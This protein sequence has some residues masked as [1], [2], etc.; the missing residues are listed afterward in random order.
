MSGYEYTVSRVVDA[1]VAKVW[2]VWTQPEHY[3][4]VFHAVPG[5]AVLDVR[6]G[7]SWAVTMN[8]PDAGEF[9]MSGS[10]RDVVPNQRL[11]TTMDVPG[12][13]PEAMAMDLKDLGG[14]RTELILSQTCDTAEK[15]DESKQG[16][17]VLLEWCADYLATL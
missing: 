16:S 9:P 5:S 17:E 6:P 15:R 1:P 8:V 13:E 4:G 10:Y 7:G 3:A 14:G 11:V 12:G 2:E